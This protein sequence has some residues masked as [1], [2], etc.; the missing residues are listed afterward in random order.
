MIGGFLAMWS[1]KSLFYVDGITAILAG[2]LIALMPWRTQGQTVESSSHTA[3]ALGNQPAAK[4]GYA[5]V[6]RDRRYVLFLL[7][8]LPVEMVFFQTLAAMPLFVV[9]DLHISEA[10]F[11]LLLA[12]NTVLII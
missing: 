2:A 8:M 11:G 3:E 4:S 7:A 12:I 1:F 10:A 5:S 9:R 6:L